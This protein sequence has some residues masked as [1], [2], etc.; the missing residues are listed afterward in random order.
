MSPR[1]LLARLRRTRGASA[2]I[3]FAL[4]LPVV[5]SLFGSIIDISLFVTRAHVI[6]RVA[7]DAARVGS[8]TLEAGTSHTGIGITTASTAQATSALLQ[9]GLPCTAGCTVTSEWRTISGTRVI[10]VSVRYPY[11]ALMGILPLLPPEI[12]ADFTMMTQ[13]QS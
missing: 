8:A 12:R 1:S 11:N 10:F 7:R 13:Q 3:E 9:A 6:Q 4:L 2:A 5:I